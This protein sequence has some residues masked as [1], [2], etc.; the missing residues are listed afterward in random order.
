MC[1]CCCCRSSICCCKA[2]CSTE[3]VS[4][5]SLLIHD[6][7]FLTAW[8]GLLTKTGETM[9]KAH[10]GWRLAKGPLE[11]RGWSEFGEKDADEVGLSRS[12]VQQGEEMKYKRG[13][14]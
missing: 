11:F 10:G 12:K 8:E 3:R 5:L 1:C 9:P 14:W 13:C 6:S 2:S 7:V 4:E